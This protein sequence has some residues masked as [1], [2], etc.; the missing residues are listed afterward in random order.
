MN[1]TEKQ[2]ANISVASV[3]ALLCIWVLPETIVLRHALLCIGCIAGIFLI[4]KNWA[5]LIQPRFNLIPLGAIAALFFWVGIHYCFF[6]L[7]P[8]LELSEIKGLWLRSLAGCIMAIG[9]ATALSKHTYLR[10]YFYISIFAVPLI[11]LLT[12]IYDCYLFGNLVLPGNFVGF[13][14]K[15]IETAYFGGI[16]A[17][18]TV[19]N[20]IY[21]LSSKIER[22]AYPRIALNLFAIILVLL[23]AIL[24]STKNGV[25]IAL[26]LCIILSAILVAKTFLNFKGLSKPALIILIFMLA[27]MPWAWQLHKSYSYNGWDMIFQDVKVAIDI[28]KNK[29]WQFMEGSVPTP[30]NSLG[31]SAA[32]NTYS[33]FAYIAVGIRL[34]EQYPLG[35]GSVNRSFHGLQTAENIYHEHT[36]QVHSGWVDLALAF[37]LPGL[38]LIFLV[39]I[40]VIYLGI[41][42]GGELPLVALMYCVM[43][44]PFGFIA[45]ISYKQYFEATLFFL[46]FSA[47]IVAISPKAHEESSS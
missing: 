6:S 34:I 12:Y 28:D 33:R 42:Q 29:Q 36:G 13:Y 30:L 32:Q 9:F 26:G 27:V 47:T 8:E 23:S 31:V 35:Y 2:L 24:S 1:I 17:A 3:C 41:R 45:E 15:K 25:A 19:A 20:L 18:A 5:Q 22:K 39:S 44:I 21:L 40:L 7:N 4:R 11:N 46:A 43:L 10:K 16:A 14:F 37:G 38:G